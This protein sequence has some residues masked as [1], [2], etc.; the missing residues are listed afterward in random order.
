MKVFQSIGI[1][2]FVSKV[3]ISGRNVIQNIVLFVK[4]TAYRTY[5]VG[6]EFVG[7][8]A[9][10]IFDYP[11]IYWIIPFIFIAVIAFQ[12]SGEGTEKHN[13]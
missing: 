6:T 1:T 10:R 5:E 4:N 2:D 11:A 7:R 13:I 8:L 12:P 9:Q 3:W